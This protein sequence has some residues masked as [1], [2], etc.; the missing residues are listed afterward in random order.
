MRNQLLPVSTA[1]ITILSINALCTQPVLHRPR[2][3]SQVPAG[4]EIALDL[5]SETLDSSPDGVMSH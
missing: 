2:W 4:V 3:F 1:E 5:K